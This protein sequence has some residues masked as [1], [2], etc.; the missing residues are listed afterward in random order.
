MRKSDKK[1][2]NQLRVALTEVCDE[3]L[4]S[5][6]DFQ[7]LTHLVNY[8][9]VSKSLKVICVFDT[10]ENLAGFMDSNSCFKLSHLIQKKLFEMDINLKR[11][12]DHISYDTEENCVNN[13]NGNWA[14]R[15]K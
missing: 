14:E 8:T 1:I 9:N 7:W 10:N 3:A 4:K 6:T 11:I 15:L 13:N 2:E 5:F 12:I